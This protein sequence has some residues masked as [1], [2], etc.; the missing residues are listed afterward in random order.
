MATGSLFLTRKEIPHLPTAQE[1]PQPLRVRRLYKELK[2]AL[3]NPSF[4]IIFISGLFAGTLLGINV[5]LGLHVSTYF[6]ELDSND[7]AFLTT[8]TLLAAMTAFILMRW[9][10]KIEKKKAYIATCLL[11]SFAGVIVVLRLFDMLPP[12]GS[13]LLLKIIYLNTLYMYTLI[14]LQTILVASIIAD[15][16][17]EGELIAGVRQEGM[18][19]AFL[20]F[21]SKAFSGLGSLFAGL[22][23]DFIGLPAKL[24]PGAVEPSIIWN[25]GLIIGPILG[26]LWV[27]PFLII[28]RLRMSRSR[29][30]EI[31]QQLN[32]RK[33]SKSP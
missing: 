27:I 25:L 24:A 33:V 13:P 1:K 4:R 2:T 3:A 29:M 15:T 12:N 19:F 7:L 6:W 11:S 22:I 31:R 23:I 8:A 32:T 30:V 26:I 9:L 20:T 17:D 18:Y 28:L 14:I 21:S 16:V 5:N 10:E